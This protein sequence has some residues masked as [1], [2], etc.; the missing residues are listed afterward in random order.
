M[1]IF[2]KAAFENLKKNKSRTLVTIAGVV[3]SAALMTAG[4]TF[5][6]S[7]L[8]YMV[9][10]AE[11]K[12]GSWHAAFKEVPSS[13]AQ[14]R[15]KDEE[16][17]KAV[18]TE[19]LGYA[20]LE[21]SKNTKSPYVFI[22]GYDEDA[23]AML[24]VQLISGRLPE[25]SS[26]VVVSGGVVASGGVN[27]SEGD[28]LNLSVGER[29]K[30]GR[31]LRQ[32][33]PYEK[34][35]EELRIREKK[36]YTV[37]GICSK[38]AYADSDEPGYL[39]IT[40]QK[41]GEKT[42]SSSVFVRLENVWKAKDYVKSKGEG[43]VVS[44]ND[45]VLR[46]L[47]VSGNDIFNFLLYTV[48]GI[49]VAIIM[50]GSVCLIRNTFSISLNERTRQFGLLMSAGATKKQLQNSVLFEGF[51]IGAAGIPEGVLLGIAGTEA[52]ILAVSKKFQGILYDNVPLKVVLSAPVIL[53]AVF[54]SFITILISAWLPARRAV[55][56]P[57]MECIRQTN[58]VKAEE[59]NVRTG[60]LSWYFFGLPGMLAAKSFKRNKRRYR[61]TVFSLVLSVVLFVSVN[62][63][64]IEMKQASEAAVVFT[65]YNLAFSAADM[66]DEK[67]FSLWERFK[68]AAEVTESSYQ[69]DINCHVTVE[70]DKLT[71][72]LKKVM[73]IPDGQ[74]EAKLSVLLQIL[75]DDAYQKLAKAAGFSDE[76]GTGKD[77]GLLTDAVVYEESGRM[78]EADEF[79]NMFRNPEE[80][81]TLTLP[82]KKGDGEGTGA[83]KEQKAA[84]KL[85]FAKITMPDIVPVLSKGDSPRQVPYVFTVAAP[86]SM[87]EQLVTPDTHIAGKGL[88]F[89]SNAPSRTERD[90]R[91]FISDA[92]V[93]GRYL[94]FNSSKMAEQNNNMIFIAN[95]FCYTFI[96]MITLIAIANVFNTISTNI[97]LRRRELAML[98]SVGMAE[99][100]F[101]EMMNFECLLYGFQSLMWGLPLS[102]AASGGIYQIMQF[103]A[104]EIDFVIPWLAVAV[105][106]LGVFLIVFVTMLYSVRQIKR[107]NIIDALRDDM[108]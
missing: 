59:E 13:F 52:V 10:G 57:V 40:R 84:V 32:T 107:E 95:V 53:A 83:A 70:T 18:V 106:I 28:I 42:A 35:K 24:P 98:R 77:V 66:P 62:S 71:Q 58:E 63:F 8:S 46:F 100:E 101:Q 25:N 96:A 12:A 36:S 37:V 23:F 102:L 39:L 74:K 79:P 55:R 9:R 45:D 75:D 76:E 2:H 64:V 104:E 67:L 31:K 94:L 86:Y 49:A 48:G 105:S 61:S 38:P 47:G 41:K 14:E 16:T 5:G 73:D 34:G 72:K 7:L 44:L 80:E 88:T 4:A 78:K 56:I 54:L 99:R 103:G 6:I 87:K 81:L 85:R 29:I 30:D 69:E 1:N 60:R 51:L 43:A 50:L 97:K 93:D 91:Q 92:D 82:S 108:V 20:K 22:T 17:D 89:S 3:L 11:S 15:K 68:T 27:L 21:G 65:T 33:E 19:N 90:M 26:E